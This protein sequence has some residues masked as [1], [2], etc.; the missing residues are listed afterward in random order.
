MSM[1]ILRKTIPMNAEIGG[2][3]TILLALRA[4][5]DAEAPLPR[6]EPVLPLRSLPNILIIHKKM[7]VE[8]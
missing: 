4:D 3:A 7:Q 6:H 5:I 1:N 2:V 8:S